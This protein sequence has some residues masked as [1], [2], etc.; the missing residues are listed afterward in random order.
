M[1]AED[2]DVVKLIENLQGTCETLDK[3]LESLYP[4]MTSEDLTEDDH[5]AIDQEIFK[6]ETC[7][8]WYEQCESGDAEGNCLNCN[9]EIDEEE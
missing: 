5:D 9:N 3:V 8:W 2:F 6:R 7:D 4:G 1:R